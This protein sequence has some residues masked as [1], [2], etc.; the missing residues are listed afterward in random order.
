[1]KIENLMHFWGNVYPSKNSAIKEDVNFDIEYEPTKCYLQGIVEDIYDDKCVLKYNLI[2]N[3]VVIYSGVLIISECT[4]NKNKKTKE[5]RVNIPYKNYIGDFRNVF[6][7]SPIPNDVK[8]K[9]VDK[10]DKKVALDF[11]K[12][13][14]K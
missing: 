1:M 8:Q 5:Y 7:V 9:I 13:V 14:F 10:I 2:H 6:G 3:P 11:S 12:I 4:L